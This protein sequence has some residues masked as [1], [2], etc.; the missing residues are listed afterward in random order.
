MKNFK[1]KIKNKNKGY[2]IL[3]TVVIVGVILSIASGMA[4]VAYKELILSSVAQDSQIAFYEAD[5]GGECALYADLVKNL[6]FGGS[7]FVCGK[8]DSGQA[9]AFDTTGITQ[10]AVN[11][12]VP[13]G[14]GMLGTFK[15]AGFKMVFMPS[16]SNKIIQ[17][18]GYNNFDTTNL[19]SVERALNITY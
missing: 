6:T 8:D 18:F 9:I 1:L 2:A 12:L 17:S 7:D 3:F 10:G 16:G 5:T 19:R 13:K 4:N 11:T 14:P 15:G